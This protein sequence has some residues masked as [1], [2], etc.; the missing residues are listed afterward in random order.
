[1]NAGRN[2][3][4]HLHHPR[5][6][7]RG[8]C[9]C[10]LPVVGFLLRFDLGQIPQC[11]F[12]SFFPFLRRPQ[13]RGLLAFGRGR[14]IFVQFATQD[15]K[16]LL[17]I[18]KQLFQGRLAA[19]GRRSGAG[20]N[21]YPVLGDTLH[22]H[23]PF[24][25]QRRYADRQLL[26]QELR[27]RHPKVRQGVVIDRYPTTEPTVGVVLQAQARQCPRAADA[28]DRRIQPQGNE[29]HR[30]DRRTPGAPFHCTNA[31]I[32]RRQLHPLDKR[33]HRSHRVILRNQVFERTGVQL[34]LVTVWASVTRGSFALRCLGSDRLRWDRR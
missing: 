33:P 13:L 9:A 28:L 18:G 20:A 21:A 32:Q 27:V 4:G 3:I 23:Q 29:D 34:E 8:R 12:D 17:G 2:P 5:L 1:L 31:L 19:K 11:F 6:G 16:L 7:I 10:L 14:G 25:L 15:G 22:F 30:I 26:V 24:L